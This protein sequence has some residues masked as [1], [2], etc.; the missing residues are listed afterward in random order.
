MKHRELKKQDQCLRRPL[1]Y[2]HEMKLKMLEDEEGE[3]MYIANYDKY[4]DGE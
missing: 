3:V 1:E 4:R 2:L